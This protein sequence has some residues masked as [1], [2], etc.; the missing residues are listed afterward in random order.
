MSD[1]VPPF[2]F[3]S[4]P[5]SSILSPWLTAAEAAN[6]ARVGIKTIYGAVRSGRLRAARIGGR[7]ELRFLSLW[8]DAWLEASAE[9]IE[10]KRECV[11]FSR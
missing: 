7:R 4:A 3:E 9:P 2:A 11:R 1:S 6:H 10:I 5:P 8:V